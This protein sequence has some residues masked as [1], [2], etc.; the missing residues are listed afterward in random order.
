M[1]YRATVDA[2]ASFVFCYILEDQAG[3]ADPKEFQWGYKLYDTGYVQ[4]FESS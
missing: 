3:P 2:D 1:L 4:M